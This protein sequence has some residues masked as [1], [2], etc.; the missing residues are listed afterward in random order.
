MDITYAYKAPEI[1][2]FTFMVS[3]NIW[4]IHFYE[5]SLHA[6]FVKLQSKVR[7]MQIMEKLIPQILYEHYTFW[8][9]CYTF[10]SH[11]TVVNNF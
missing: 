6:S 3:E 10:Y 5:I 11:Q 2:F 8:F 1:T 9:H 7:P 4:F